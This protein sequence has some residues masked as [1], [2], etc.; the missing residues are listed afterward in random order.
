[1]NPVDTIPEVVVVTSSETRQSAP[2]PGLTRLVGA[3]NDKLFLVEY[4]M[5]KS[6]V[7]AAHSHPQEQ[8]VCVISGGMLIYGQ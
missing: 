3:C 5:E 7:G 8:I 6:W 2:E 1:M 4:R